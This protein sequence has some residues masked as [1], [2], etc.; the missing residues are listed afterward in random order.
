MKDNE[1]RNPTTK[2][3]RWK[4]WCL[5]CGKERAEVRVMFQTDGNRHG[6]ICAECVEQFA[7]DLHR[8]PLTVPPSLCEILGPGAPHDY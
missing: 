8:P 4:T 7:R 2:P 1:P 3:R 6:G 5:F